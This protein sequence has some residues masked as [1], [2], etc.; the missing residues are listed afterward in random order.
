MVGQNTMPVVKTLQLFFQVPVCF[1]Q[2]QGIYQEF[3]KEPAPGEKALPY[4][5]RNILGRRDV[6]GATSVTKAYR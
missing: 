5:F 2:L 6:D 3:Y 4:C 1:I